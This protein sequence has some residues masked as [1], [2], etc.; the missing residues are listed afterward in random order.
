MK[1]YKIINKIGEGVYSRVYKC[2][3]TTGK[4]YAMKIY[5]KDDFFES[6]GKKEIE[7][8]K[9]LNGHH[10]FPQLYDSFNIDGKIHIIQDYLSGNLE[11]KLTH[12]TYSVYALKKISKDVLLGLQQLNRPD[13]PIIHGDLKPDNLMMSG[14]DVKIIDFSNAF[15][16]D[17]Y[18]RKRWGILKTFYS[19]FK[20]SEIPYIQAIPYRSPE[21]ILETDLVEKVDIW[22]LGCILVELFT[23]N[24]LFDFDTNQD[25]LHMEA[26]FNMLGEDYGIT[27]YVRYD[28]MEY[29]FEMN[30]YYDFYFKK[31]YKV[32]PNRTLDSILRENNIRKGKED[33]SD[34]TD[35]LKCMLVINPI[36]RWT[37]DELLEHDYLKV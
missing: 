27:E 12:H 30:S 17:K 8:L 4:V 32:S 16:L 10:Y 14:N 24:I 3:D 35:F 33:L 5:N 21:I 18:D 7:F 19:F 37:V 1:P 2:T 13:R 20:D 29:F 22:S 31:S 26:I 15:Y 34:F 25:K 23:G 6:S 28:V 36:D 9:Q 11:D